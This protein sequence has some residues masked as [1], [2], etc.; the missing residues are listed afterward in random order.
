MR[1]T[2][3]TGATG[4]LGKAFAKIYA[5]NGNNLLLV[6][7]NDEKL[8]TLKDELENSFN[9]TVDFISADFADKTQLK[10]VYE[11]AKNKEYFV[12][13][14]VNCAGFGDRTDFIDMDV[15]LQLKMIDVNCNALLYFCRVFITDMVK[16]NEGHIINACSLAAFVPGPYMC[17]YHASKAFV[18][19]LTESIAHEI[20]KTKVKILALCPGPFISGFVEKAKNDWTFKKIKPVSAD[21]IALFGYKK[22]IKGKHI[23]IPGFTNKLT[24]FAPRFF[25]RK[26]VAKVSAGT[27]KKGG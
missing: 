18:L 2:L 22:S 12:N 8:T 17:T 16:N 13:N 15:D 1:V 6:G 19:N 5:K 10:K 20:R 7:T 23:A 24:A 14:L 11:Y 25:T 27:L 9:V 26:F 4:G 21:K 3:I